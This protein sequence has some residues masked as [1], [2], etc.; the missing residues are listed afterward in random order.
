[1]IVTLPIRRSDRPVTQCRRPSPHIDI[2]LTVDADWYDPPLTRGETRDLASGQAR[3]LASSFDAT[4]D[5]LRVLLELASGQ[6]VERVPVAI[7]SGVPDSGAFYVSS[8]SVDLGAVPLEGRRGTLADTW[9]ADATRKLKELVSHYC[10]I[11]ET[12]LT[13]VAR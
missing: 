3:R 4:S 5:R 9:T 12:S 10:D 11:A 6:I 2:D 13:L 8:L 1:M 7:G